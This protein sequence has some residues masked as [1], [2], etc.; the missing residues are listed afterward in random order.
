MKVVLSKISDCLFSITAGSVLVSLFEDYNDSIFIAFIAAT[1][2]I[3]TTIATQI[4]E[5]N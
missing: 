1:C 3:I 2:A 5:D 4:M